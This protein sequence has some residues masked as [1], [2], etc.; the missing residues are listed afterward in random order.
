MFKKLILMMM[1]IAFGMSTMAVAEDTKPAEAAAPAVTEAAPAA[2]ED[3]PAAPAA[4]APAA[5]APA[6]FE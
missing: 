2:V 5:E 3:A 6:G 4:D 1:L